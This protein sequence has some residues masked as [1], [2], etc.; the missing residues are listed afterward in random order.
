MSIYGPL[1]HAL[2]IPAVFQAAFVAAALLVAAGFAVRRQL[3]AA[4][5][6]VIP[7][8]GVT[9]RNMIEIVIESIDNLARDVIGEDHRRF[10][11]LVGTIFV[12]ILVSNFMG[13]VPGLG[14]ATS[15]INTTVAWGIISFVFYNYVGIQKHGL[16]KY[17][18]QLMGPSFFD[19]TIFGKKI[20]MRLMAWFFFPIEFIL[21]WARIATLAIRLLAN[22]FADHQVVAV[23]IGLV[24]FA[25]PAVFMGLGMV[26]AVIQAFVFSLLT[27]IYI[28]MALDEP[29]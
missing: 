3:A 25:I 4:N 24:P 15:D 16:P 21:H 23:W 9:L 12:F 10:M 27:M 13:M 2:G 6:G 19:A 22:M 11:P 18:T 29:H 8:E 14:G 20:H 26:V 1:E 5:G 28:R 17:M 7:D